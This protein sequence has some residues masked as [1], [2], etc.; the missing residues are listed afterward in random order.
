MRNIFILPFLCVL[1]AC[2]GIDSEANTSGAN[3]SHI[4]QISAGERAQIESVLYEK[5]LGGQ[6]HGDAEL[7]KSAFNVDSVMF[8]PSKSEDG[9]DYLHKWTDMHSV[10]TGW[11]K[12]A[13]PDL[14]IQD[15]EILSV[16]AVDER[17]AVV[18]FKYNTSVYDAITLVKID[19]EW[20]I[21][22]KVYI[23]Q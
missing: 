22:A 19:D 4:L 9:T 18:L 17:M 2:G 23:K 11:A 6:I 15:Y 8:R 16:N 1:A 3:S 13:K 12:D 21:A 10:V 14:N 20:Q 7:L 5:Y